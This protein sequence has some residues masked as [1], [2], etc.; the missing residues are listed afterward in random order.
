MD[1]WDA[2]NGFRNITNIQA[3][4]YTLKDLTNNQNYNVYVKYKSELQNFEFASKEI[5]YVTEKSEVVIPKTGVAVSTTF[6][7]LAL[8][9]AVGLFKFAKKKNKFKL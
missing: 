4:S 7:V 9:A 3:G 6:G 8:S 1:G 5:C 2:K